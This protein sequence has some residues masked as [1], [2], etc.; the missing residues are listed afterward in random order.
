MTPPS[1]AI[2]KHLHK[3]TYES[4]ITPQPSD[5][6]ILLSIGARRAISYPRKLGLGWKSCLGAVYM[7]AMHLHRVWVAVERHI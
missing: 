3:D 7:G 1:P 2:Q 6:P 5:R 4:H